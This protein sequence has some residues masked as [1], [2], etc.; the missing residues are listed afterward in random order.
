MS[1]HRY[2]WHDGEI[3]ELDLNAPRPPSKG[4]YI[5]RDQGE[6]RSVI[7]GEMITSRSRHREHLREHNCLEVGNEMP[8]HTPAALPPL[9][10]D[11]RQAMQA[12]PER[13]AEAAAVAR[14]AADAGP[15]EAI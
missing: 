8:R 12:S 4:P 14:A 15:I 11:L 5:M 2:I 1:R 7:T 3:V 13:H 6:Y 9:R 10:D